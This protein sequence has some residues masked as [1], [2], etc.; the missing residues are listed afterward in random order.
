MHWRRMPAK[1]NGKV[2]YIVL[3]ALTAS[4]VVSTV[5]LVLHSHA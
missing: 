3:L 1:A 5:F 4:V 2:F